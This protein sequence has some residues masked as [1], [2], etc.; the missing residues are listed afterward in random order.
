MGLTR[1]RCEGCGNLRLFDVVVIRR[2]SEVHRFSVGGIRDV[3]D[4][5][6][7]AESVDQISCRWCGHGDDV[8]LLQDAEGASRALA[9][10]GAASDRED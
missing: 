8:V 10:E 5:E 9:S 4:T 3:G 7:L 1:Y 2:S 6:L